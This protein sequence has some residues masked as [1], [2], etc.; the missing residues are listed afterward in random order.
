MR[1]SKH[2]H[3]LKTREKVEV[4]KMVILLYYY[5]YY[6]YSLFKKTHIY[7]EKKKW[8]KTKHC[9]QEST[10]LFTNIRLLLAVLE[11]KTRTI[12]NLCG[13][14]VAFLLMGEKLHLRSPLWQGR[15]F[16]QTLRVH[17]FFLREGTSKME[18]SKATSQKLRKFDAATQNTHTHW[19]GK[20]R[21]IVAFDEI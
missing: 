17:F 11:L 5:D 6:Y 14:V 13:W 8:Y 7:I 9:K 1:R 2:T 12:V 18:P 20:I 3:R 19:R 4:Y 16:R 15:R 10:E 21:K